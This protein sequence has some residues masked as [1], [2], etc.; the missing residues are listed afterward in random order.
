MFAAAV[1]L[2]AA[3][4]VLVPRQEDAL[5]VAKIETLIGHGTGFA[6]SRRY[7]ITNRHV[8]GSAGRVTVRF[9]KITLSGEVVYRSKTIDMAVIRV[10]AAPHW[11]PLACDS[12]NMIGRQ[13]RVIGYPSQLGLQI[14]RGW[15]TG[16]HRGHLMLT[17]QILPGSSGSPVLHRGRVV[18]LIFAGIGTRIGFGTFI[19]HGFNLAVKISRVCGELR[20]FNFIR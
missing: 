15:T 2:V 13:V 4:F 16:W 19:P 3:F 20:K 11:L 5:A 10:K 6:I 18:G 12:G 8:V 7:V 14:T 9:G 17:A 1:F